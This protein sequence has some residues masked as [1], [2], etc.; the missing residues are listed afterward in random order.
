MV[1]VLAL[2]G[3]FCTPAVFDRLAA[4]LTPDLPLKTWSW[5]TRPGPWDIPALA[6]DLARHLE[7]PVALLGHS[8][9]GA[10]ALQLVLSRP[11][12]VTHLVLVDTGAH[13][14]DHGDVRSILRALTAGLAPDL[15][16]AVLDRSFH[17]PL[18]PALREEWLS[19]ATDVNPQAAHDAL[20]SQHDL[21]FRPA[22]SRITAPTLVLHGEYDQARPVHHAQELADGIP[23]ARLQVLPTGHTPVH[24]AP[25]LVAAWIRSHIL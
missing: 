11:D 1:T 4:E 17:R 19:W 8:T 23:G 12:L 6:D 15:L 13:M 24:E 3:S 7:G 20:A 5:L 2:P 25:D 14:K 9:G 21:D 18:E 22:L 16:A 10:I